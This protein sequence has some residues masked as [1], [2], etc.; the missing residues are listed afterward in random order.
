MDPIKHFAAN[1]LVLAQISYIHC[2]QSKSSSSHEGIHVVKLFHPYALAYHVFEPDFH[3]PKYHNHRN[4]RLRRYY[5]NQKC[6]NT[7]WTG[8]KIG[9]LYTPPSLRNEDVKIGDIVCLDA[10]HNKKGLYGTSYLPPSWSNC[11]AKFFQYY[12][13]PSKVRWMLESQETRQILVK[14]LMIRFYE[15]Q[16]PTLYHALVCLT[17]KDFSTIVDMLKFKRLRTTTFQTFEE[18]QTMPLTKQT[19]LYI[20]DTTQFVVELALW[21]QYPELLNI[22][23]TQLQTD[24]A[25]NSTSFVAQA[26]DFL[27][28]KDKM[29]IYMKRVLKHLSKRST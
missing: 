11:I 6:L 16:L 17:T 14:D 24:M 13:T 10:K 27:Q 23:A 4:T 18:L 5:L 22:F 7:T 2:D 29:I 8:R 28:K 21:A 20:P 3:L 25:R 19:N 1:S 15:V 12:C 26:R 9:P